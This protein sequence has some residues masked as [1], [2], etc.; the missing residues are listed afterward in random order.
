MDKYQE[1]SIFVCGSDHADK[2]AL[3]EDYSAFRKDDHF[4]V[5]AVS[6]GGNE[7][8]YFRSYLGARFAVEAALDS[9]T[10]FASSVSKDTLFADK[11]TQTR[12]MRQLEGSIVVNWNEKV[13][14][15]L[16]NYPFQEE[17]LDSVESDKHRQGYQEGVHPEY[18]YWANV[19]AAVA[20][21]G[22]CLIIRGGNGECV[23]IEKD[24]KVTDPLPV[25]RR[26][27]SYALCRPNAA[28]EFSYCCSDSV[29]SS[30][31]LV[32][33]GVRRC[34]P[35]Q[36]DYHAYLLELTQML[37]RNPNDGKE[38][39]KADLPMLS[40]K[41][42]HDDMCLA[43]VWSSE[44]LGK[45]PAVLWKTDVEWEQNAEWKRAVWS[46]S[47]AERKHKEEEAERKRK[48]EE[49]RKRKKALEETQKLIKE[50]RQAA[51]AAAN[52]AFVAAQQTEDEITNLFP[53]TDQEAR[54]AIEQAAEE[55]MAA[56]AAASDED[57]AARSATD[58]PLVEAARKAAEKACET[59]QEALDKARRIVKETAEKE[60]RRIEAE[61]AEKARKQKQA[62][63]FK[64]MAAGAAA[65]AIAAFLF[66]GKGD[67]DKKETTNAAT[68]EAESSLEDKV[69]TEN[70]PETRD[71]EKESR[72]RAELE[73]SIR[74]SIR[75]ESVLAASIKES[76]EE[77]S[78]QAAL[79]EESSNDSSVSNSEL[80]DVIDHLLNTE[81]TETEP[82]ETTAPPRTT[83][84][85]RQTTA[86]PP[87]TT[88]PPQTAPPETAPPETAPP[89]TNPPQP[90]TPPPPP[91]TQPETSA[92]AGQEERD[93]Y[94]DLLP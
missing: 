30:V 74:E 49:E 46:K 44:K 13:N 45:G 12:L 35:K 88:A 52:K 53:A 84:A 80:L 19:T 81:E 9:L 76:L 38:Y 33:E 21:D 50:A 37:L 39:L 10:A 16:E 60:T 48:E 85:P 78:R 3:C 26:E 83:A 89:E 79:A 34:F 72:E 57:R 28:R 14:R 2:Q 23:L 55:A 68:T 91:P 69:E 77:E 27:D 62:A 75:Q 25:T 17:E 56:A 43:A 67:S 41:G 64:K 87:Q 7:S 8:Q 70:Q 40:R 58:L 1:L 73:E 11:R 18:A 36:E 92:P 42:S 32:T 22:Y 29:P 90:E 4:S 54:W 59:A 71:E 94:S 51:E 31:F 47:E 93:I 5:I 86:A 15:H 6:S 20:A 61:K 63:L 82:L 65:I 66:G 24:G